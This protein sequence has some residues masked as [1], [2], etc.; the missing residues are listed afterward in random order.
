MRP[1]PTIEVFRHER[2]YLARFSS[3]DMLETFEQDTLPTAYTAAADPLDV[4]ASVTR[5]NPGADVLLVGCS[6]R[7]LDTGGPRSESSIS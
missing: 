3:P 5:D 2:H 1:R 4:L 7:T 6:P